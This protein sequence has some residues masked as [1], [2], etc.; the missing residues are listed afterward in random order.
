LNR[1]TFSFWRNRSLVG[2][3]A[4][5]YDTSNGG[6]I[7][8]TMKRE[9]RQLRKFG[10]KPNVALCGADF[11]DAMERE[12][13]ANGQYYVDGPGK[14][15]VDLDVGTIR[16]GNLRFEYDP[17]LDDLGFAK[18]CYIW[19]DKDLFLMKMPGEWNRPHAPARPVNQFVVNRSIT[20]TGQMIARRLNSAGVYA[21]Q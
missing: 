2:A 12:Y 19:S 3:N 6:N 5:V 13:R 4:I 15:D 10:G 17:S 9:I 1:A 18:R 7:V 8:Q 20:C 14:G 11:I 21:I 16:M